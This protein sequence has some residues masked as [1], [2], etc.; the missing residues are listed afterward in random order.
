MWGFAFLLPVFKD[1][2]MAAMVFTDYNS[3]D[4]IPTKRLEEADSGKKAH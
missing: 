1:R 2:P 4:L 3:R